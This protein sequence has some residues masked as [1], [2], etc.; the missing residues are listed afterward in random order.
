[1]LTLNTSL[2]VTLNLT[3]VI[4][5]TNKGASGMVANVNTVNQE[6]VRT[7]QLVPTLLVNVLKLT[8]APALQTAVDALLLTIVRGAQ[9]LINVLTIAHQDVP[10]LLGNV[11]TV[12]ATIITAAPVVPVSPVVSLL[13]ENVFKVPKHVHT[14][15]VKTPQMNAQVRQPDVLPITIAQLAFGIINPEVVNV[16]GNQDSAKII[17]IVSAPVQL[18][19]TNANSRNL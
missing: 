1:M 3:V 16:H 15:T 14:A 5:L 10:T 7:T 17:A 6:I 4:V 19:I 12:T 18:K 8:H 2:H 13:R 9:L 11:H